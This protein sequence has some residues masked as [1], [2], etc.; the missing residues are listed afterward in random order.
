VPTKNVANRA[1]QLVAAVPDSRVAEVA[2]ICQIL[3]NLSVGK[4]KQSAQL[5]ATGGFVAVANEML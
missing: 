3:A 5:A 2:K 4:S 1:D